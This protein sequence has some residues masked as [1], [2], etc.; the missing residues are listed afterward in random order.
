MPTA[1]AKD[2]GQVEHGPMR[3]LTSI[4]LQPLTVAG[5][6]TILTVG[7]AL[8]FTAPDGR[9]PALALLA[10]FLVLFLLLQRHYIQGLLLGGVKG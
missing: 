5:L 9:L 3:Q 6:L 4:L 2:R 7:Y 8:R 1:I 10:A